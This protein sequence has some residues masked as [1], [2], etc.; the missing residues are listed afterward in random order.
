[1]NGGKLNRMLFWAALVCVL[2]GWFGFR[3]LARDKAVTGPMPAESFEYSGERKALRKWMLNNGVSGYVEYSR[4]LYGANM[5]FDWE[6]VKR[7]ARERPQVAG[8][9]LLALA[10]L[11]PPPRALAPTGRMQMWKLGCE[12]HDYWA[13]VML[14]RSAIDGRRVFSI[15]RWSDERRPLARSGEVASNC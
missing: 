13:V 11:S 5:P 10:E 14:E 6:Q 9:P 3:P 12:G 7:F 2:L 1:M 15:H 4:T 8:K